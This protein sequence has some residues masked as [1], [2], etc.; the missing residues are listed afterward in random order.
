MSETIWPIVKKRNLNFKIPGK[1]NILLLGKGLTNV[2]DAKEQSAL[3][4]D[5]QK[6]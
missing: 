6:I 5:H 4:V 1:Y 3:I 2:R